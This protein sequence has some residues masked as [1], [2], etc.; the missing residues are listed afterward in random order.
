MVK[1]LNCQIDKLLSA[2][3]D[4]SLSSQLSALN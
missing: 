1:L 3:P 4:S 2:I